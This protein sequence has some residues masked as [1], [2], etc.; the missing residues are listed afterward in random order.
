MPNRGEGGEVFPK[1]HS[2]LRGVREGNDAQ[3]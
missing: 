3:V 2:L 1:S